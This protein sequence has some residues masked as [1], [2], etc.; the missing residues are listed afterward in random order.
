M[1]TKAAFAALTTTA[2][3]GVAVAGCATQAK[4]VVTAPGAGATSEAVTTTPS[5]ATSTT[6]ATT[7]PTPSSG[8]LSKEP[9]ITVPSAPAPNKLVVKNLINGTG[10]TA[11][12]GSQVTVNYVGALYSNGK[13]FDASWNRKQ[14][15]QF[16]LGTGAVIPGWDQGLVGMKVGG[17]REL[18]I[19]PKLAYGKS[20]QG[21]IPGNATLIFVVDMLSAK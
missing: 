1:R 7:V 16:Q 18:I 6:A 15:F 12:K 14:T 19:P 10:A 9:K 21:S 20:G 8:P 4:G 3:V 5:T 13:V 17:R 11:K 2:A